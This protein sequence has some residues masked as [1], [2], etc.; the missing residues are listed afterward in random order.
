MLTS[1]FASFVR[2]I[3]SIIFENNDRRNKIQ[4]KSDWKFYKKV[5]FWLNYLH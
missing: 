4:N 3:S 5:S 1:V 2:Y